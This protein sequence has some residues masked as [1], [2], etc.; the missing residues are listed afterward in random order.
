[1]SR[2]PAGLSKDLICLRAAK[3]LTPGMYVNLGIGLPT[4]VANFVPRGVILHSQNGVLG[5]GPIAAEE[6]MDWEL[7]NAG[8]QPITLSP[9]ISFFNSVDAFAMMR[10]RHL[11]VAILGAYQVSEKGDLAN[12]RMEGE[13]L[14]AIGGSMD[15]AYGA[16]RIIVICE[17]INKAGRP[18]IVKKCSLPLTGKRVVNTIITNLGVMEITRKGIELRALAPGVT[19]AEVQKHTGPKLMLSDDLKEMEF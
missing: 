17:H 19:T 8:A 4:Q 16:K 7:V 5:F 10:G 12:W 11:D 14:G 3:E 9:G 2:Q 15:L 1:M 13:P 6:E 18:R